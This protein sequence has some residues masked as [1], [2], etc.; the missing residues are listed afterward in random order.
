[1]RQYS[2]LLLGNGRLRP[3]K[4]RQ[5]TDPPHSRSFSMLTKRWKKSRFENTEDNARSESLP[6]VCGGPSSSPPAYDCPTQ[7]SLK[8]AR[9]NRNAHRKTE[10]TKR[11]QRFLFS[12]N[13]L[14]SPVGVYR[15]SRSSL[16]ERRG[17]LLK[18]S[19]GRVW[20]IYQHDYAGGT[21]KG[22]LPPFWQWV[23][24][25]EVIQRSW[26][27]GGLVP[28]SFGKV[29]ERYR[30]TGSALCTRFLLPTRAAIASDNALTG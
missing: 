3:L 12:L 18:G 30:D 27:L 26:G 7:S 21:F 11:R 9:K 2:A 28:D 1:M 10:R 15:G 14:F 19:S 5:L 8:M 22:S 4:R 23:G 25:L 29:S 6:S 20:L 17:K 16:T 24:G 13:A